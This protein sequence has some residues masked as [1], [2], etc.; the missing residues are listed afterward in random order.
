[1]DTNF[2][3]ALLATHDLY[4][5]RALQWKAWLL[6]RGRKL[7]TTELVLWETLNA[8]AVP[9]TRGQAVA[10]YR[11]CQQGKGIELVRFSSEL[12]DAALTLYESRPDKAWSLTDCHSF[13]I[14]RS[15]NL[16]D[17][18]TADHH[19]RQAGFHALLLHEPP[20]AS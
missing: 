2:W 1:V 9:D 6:D 13:L 19:F 7:L 16:T 12:L 14:M 20:H 18:L 15:R 11:Q 4:G 5:D 10:I 8:L 17:A 3:I